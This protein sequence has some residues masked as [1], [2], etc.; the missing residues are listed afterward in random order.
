MNLIGPYDTVLCVVFCKVQDQGRMLIATK[1]HE[2][3]MK[4]HVTVEFH[5]KL[6]CCIWLCLQGATRVL[7]QLNIWPCS[8]TILEFDRYG[9]VLT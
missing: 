3:E 6:V 7:G 2:A 1:I 8:C 4:S 5:S 9:F